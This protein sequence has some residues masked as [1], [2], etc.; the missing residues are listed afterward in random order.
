MEIYSQQKQFFLLSCVILII[1]RTF[2]C[3]FNHIHN[4]ILHIMID[5]TISVLLKYRILFNDFDSSTNR[6]TFKCNEI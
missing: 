5:F 2:L 4:M 3:D 6:I 1:F